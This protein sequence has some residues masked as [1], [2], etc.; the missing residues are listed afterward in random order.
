MGSEAGRLLTVVLTEARVDK[1]V[2]GRLI[3]QL[4]AMTIAAS[5]GFL[6]AATSLL[7]IPESVII[8]LV[9]DADDDPP[10]K[11]HV[12]LL[13]AKDA[14][15]TVRERVAQAA[16][17]RERLPA[18]GEKLLRELSADR[19]MRVRT[20]VGKSLASLL[21]SAAPLARL[22][23]VGRWALSPNA[24]ERAAVA[25]ALSSS[26]PVFVSDLALE[27]LSRDSASDV[28]ALA[29]RAMARRIREAPESYSRAL[30]RLSEDPARRVR[31]TAHRLLAVVMGTGTG[32]QPVKA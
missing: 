18:E 23:I 28:R 10:Q 31:R 6:D 25:R 13:L 12:L 14:R 9:D 3:A 7:T 22:E 21:E 15:D 8:D 27:E 20:A 19:S 4:S 29:A 32:S 5:A 11:K 2:R 17:L 1:S 30:A 24:H 16:V 26:V